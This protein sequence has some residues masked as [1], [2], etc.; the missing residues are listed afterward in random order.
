MSRD[1]EQPVWFPVFV[2]ALFEVLLSAEDKKGE[3]LT[4]DEVIT[5]RDNATCGFAL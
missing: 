2:P 3:P 4:Y 1:D 5:I